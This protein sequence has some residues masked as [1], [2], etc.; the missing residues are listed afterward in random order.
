LSVNLVLVNAIG[1]RGRHLH[2]RRQYF[3]SAL[4]SALKNINAAEGVRVSLR[5]GTGSAS[6]ALDGIVDG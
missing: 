2:G 3:R 6:Q 5:Y 4:P 1:H